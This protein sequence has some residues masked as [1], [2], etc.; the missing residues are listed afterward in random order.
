MMRAVLLGVVLG[1]LMPLIG[2]V[3]GVHADVP[4][5]PGCAILAHPS[6]GCNEAVVGGWICQ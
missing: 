6:P 2:A 5:C 1:C 4:R 3:A